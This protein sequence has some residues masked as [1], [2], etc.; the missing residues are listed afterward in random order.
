MPYACLPACL[1]AH[2]VI[3]DKQ[4][5]VYCPECQTPCLEDDKECFAICSRETCNM[6]GGFCTQCLDSYHPGRE[7]LNPEARLELLSKV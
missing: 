6:S 2:G 7:C 3:R 4:D 1:R 5:V